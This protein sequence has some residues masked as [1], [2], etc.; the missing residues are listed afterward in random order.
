M[1][2]VV[3]KRAR[4]LVEKSGGGEVWGRER[5][6]APGLDPVLMGGVFGSSLERIGIISHLISD[7]FQ[8]MGPE[9]AFGRSRGV[10]ARPLWRFI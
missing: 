10:V 9:S 8:A 2:V 6:G 4:S 7:L 1:V 3:C 5:G